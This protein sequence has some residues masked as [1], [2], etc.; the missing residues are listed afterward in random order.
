RLV[1]VVLAEST[2]ISR[3]R[4]GTLVVRHRLGFTS[5]NA[6]IDHSNVG[7]EGEEWILLLPLDPDAS[8]ARIRDALHK[9]TDVKV[10]IVISDTHGRPFRLG[11]VGTAIG[12][13]GI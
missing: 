10:G 3:M 11:N 4:M 5:A 7:A 2:E 12:V 8:A 9:T 6:G 1:E 13:A